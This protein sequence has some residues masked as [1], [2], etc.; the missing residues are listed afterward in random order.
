MP[1]FI[2]FV[3]FRWQAISGACYNGQSAGCSAACQVL[4]DFHYFVFS[5]AYS[6]PH[7][8]VKVKQDLA[9]AKRQ[10]MGRKKENF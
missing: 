2:T 3:C 8:T 4:L 1:D 7:E 5:L 9:A 6:V 10:R